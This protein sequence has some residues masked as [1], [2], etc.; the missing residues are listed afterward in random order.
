MTDPS[1]HPEAHSDQFERAL[2]RFTSAFGHAD[3]QV[4]VTLMRV[5]GTLGRGGMLL[6]HRMSLEVRLQKLKLAVK[7]DSGEIRANLLCTFPAIDKFDDYRELRNDIAHGLIL[8][9]WDDDHTQ[10]L[11]PFRNPQKLFGKRASVAYSKSSATV[12][13]R[14]SGRGM[15]MML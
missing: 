11:N 14:F 13:R 5:T 7:S 15:E 10:I 2:G 4:S 8:H 6:L 3:F 12:A 9:S 1:R